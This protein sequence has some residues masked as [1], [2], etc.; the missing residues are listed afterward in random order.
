MALSLSLSLT[1]SIPAAWWYV[2]WQ[3]WHCVLKPIWPDPSHKVPH[4]L[5]ACTS[6][7]FTYT[8]TVWVHATAGERF[9]Y[10]E[11]WISSGSS[12]SSCSRVDSSQ[13]Y[14]PVG[15]RLFSFWWMNSIQIKSNGCGTRVSVNPSSRNVVFTKCFYPALIVNKQNT[16]LKK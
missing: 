13:T 15:R 10:W 1:H 2:W 5:D 7:L 6:S 16:K 9:L 8:H 4:S 12:G 3:C 14:Y 11:V